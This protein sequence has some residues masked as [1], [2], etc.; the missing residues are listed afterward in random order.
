M[1]PYATNNC[2]VE[3]ASLGW[4]CSGNMNKCVFLMQVICLVCYPVHGKPGSLGHLILGT[5][6]KA[7]HSARGAL[8]SDVTHGNDILG[9]VDRPVCSTLLSKLVSSIDLPGIGKRFS[10][11]QVIQL[12]T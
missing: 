2:P 12:E 6:D 9:R 11:K 5:G 10:T 7:E 3:P 8:L 1:H 4:S